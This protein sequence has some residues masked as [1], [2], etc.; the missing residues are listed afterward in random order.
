MMQHYGVVSCMSAIIHG[1]DRP[2]GV[3]G[4][5]TTTQRRF[6]S[7]DVYFLEAVRNPVEAKQLAFVRSGNAVETNLAV[8]PGTKK[9]AAWLSANSPLP[10]SGVSHAECSESMAY[11]NWAVNPS[12]RCF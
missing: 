10:S 8:F 1:M 7:D 4:A 2:C 12:I 9:F 3:L 6:T 5:Y 11:K